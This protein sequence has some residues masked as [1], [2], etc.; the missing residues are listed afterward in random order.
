[1]LGTVLILAPILYFRELGYPKYVIALL[2][3]LGGVL[4]FWGEVNRSTTEQI[5]DL[6]D[7]IDFD[8]VKDEIDRLDS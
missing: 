8:R 5:K 6:H 1:M 7:F 3:G 2:S 4:V